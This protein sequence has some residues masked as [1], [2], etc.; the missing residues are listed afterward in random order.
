[1][2]MRSSVTVFMAVLLAMI[3]SDV[4]AQR[5]GGQPNRGGQVMRQQQVQRDRAMD[6]DRMAQRSQQVE[7]S[8]KAGSQAEKGQA[9]QGE[10]G[11]LQEGS[12]D[13]DQLRERDQIR[14][15]DRTH[16][17]AETAHG[18]AMYGSGMMTEQERN[19]YQQRLQLA[20]TDAEKSQLKAEHQAMMQKRAKQLGVDLPPPVKGQGATVEVQEQNRYRKEI[21]N[22]GD[23]E[24]IR[25]RSEEQVQHRLEDA[26]VEPDADPG[27]E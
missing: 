5:Q 19:R 13:Q 12:G 10:K 7:R 1:M 18:E 21:G 8:A 24:Q 27:S 4:M 14:D 20:T 15:Q 16:Q 2:K 17:S 25:T 6:R 3:S 22:P 11:P 9:R 23:G 26:G